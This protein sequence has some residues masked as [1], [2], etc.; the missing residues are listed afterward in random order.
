MEEEEASLCYIS[1]FLTVL[2]LRGQA[3]S[4]RHALP[5]QTTAAEKK[6][7]AELNA[8]SDA[9]ISVTFHH[10]ARHPLNTEFLHNFI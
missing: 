9:H 8:E 7:R 1:T 3:D 5:P 4:Y 2:G 10:K 6:Y